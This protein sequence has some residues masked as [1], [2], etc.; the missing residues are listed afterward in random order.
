MISSEIAAKV[1]IVALTEGII[2]L[3]V[4]D[5]GSAMIASHFVIHSA[6]LVSVALA[7]TPLAI[8]ANTAL[9]GPSDRSQSPQSKQLQ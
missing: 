6:A 2:H 8:T 1:S 7:V 3:G 9:N 4:P 5:Q